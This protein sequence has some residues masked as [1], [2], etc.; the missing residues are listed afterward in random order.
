MDPGIDPARPDQ[1]QDPST[2]AEGP[3]QASDYDS[4]AAELARYTEA[5]ERGGAANDA[6]L[7]HL[8]ELLGD[9]AGQRV[10]DAACGDGYLA[11][12]LAARGAK[13]TGIDLGP[14]LIDRARR[15]DP[16]GEIDY[17][18]ADLSEPLPGESGSFD[19]VASHLA[20]ND[21]HDY[22]G[23]IAT[24]A[25]VLRPGGRLVVAFNSPYGAV[26]RR[27]VADYFDSGASAPYGGL[28]ARGIKTYLQH[29]TLEEYLDAFVGAGLRLTKLADSTANCFQPGPDS[30]LPEGG[31]FPRFLLL[32][33]TKP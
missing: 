29:R 4:W 20:L 23:F 21:V 3:T 27:N 10:L 18:I 17:R 5:R 16:R 13:V 22:R 9:V 19:A 8:L 2:T 11:R 33:F 7:Q 12:A 1:S 15:R 26:I 31:R 28:W 24:L 30:I 25:G 32:R 14:R 6:L